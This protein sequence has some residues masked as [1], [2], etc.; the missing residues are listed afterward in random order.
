MSKKVVKEGIIAASHINGDSREEFISDVV[1]VTSESDKSIDTNK[2]DILHI[3]TKT[4]MSMSDEERTELYNK[5]IK[6]VN[7]N[8]S[9]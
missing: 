8:E 4:V 9:K 5:I 7:L 2:K 6:S 3:D 1:G